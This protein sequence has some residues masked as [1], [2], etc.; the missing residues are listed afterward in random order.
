MR[1]PW[2]KKKK[3][4]NLP[5][6]PAGILPY[7]ESSWYPEFFLPNSL[8]V[9]LDS[10][11]WNGT[12]CASHEMNISFTK[13]KKIHMKAYAKASWK[14]FNVASTSASAPPRYSSTSA[15]DH[16]THR[17]QN[18]CAQVGWNSYNE[19]SFWDSSWVFLIW[20]YCSDF[21]R[22]CW[23]ETSDSAKDSASNLASGDVRSEISSTPSRL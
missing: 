21:G 6:S 13:R 10:S 1:D 19:R 11:P 22:H 8:A 17:G 4:K 18:V 16:H 3:K 20:E 9:E 5:F 12:C 7:P 14:L 15:C 2:K 23:R